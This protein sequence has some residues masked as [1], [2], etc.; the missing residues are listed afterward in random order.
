MDSGVDM[1]V[2]LTQVRANDQLIDTDQTVALAWARTGNDDD[3]RAM[4]RQYGIDRED[5]EDSTEELLCAGFFS[6][7]LRVDWSDT[8][9][10]HVLEFRLPYG[11]GL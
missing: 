11:T 7:V 3:A 5:F 4:A 2:W 1:G 8:E 6:D 9:R 10:E